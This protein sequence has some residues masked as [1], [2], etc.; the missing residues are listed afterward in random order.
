[1]TEYGTLVRIAGV[2][3]L[4]AYGRLVALLESQDAVAGVAL[5]HVRDDAFTFDLRLRAGQTN[6]VR[7]LDASGQLSV[8]P[9][10]LRPLPPVTVAGPGGAYCSRRAR[11]RLRSICT[12]VC[13]TD[14][15]RLVKPP[16]KS[17][18]RHLPNLISAARIVLS[19]ADH[20]VSAEPR[21]HAGDMAV[22]DRRRIRSASTASWPNALAGVRASEGS[23]MRWP[24]S[25]CCSRPSSAC[26]GSACSR[27]GW[28]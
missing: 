9:A 25:S 13:V 11:L 14:H 5:R 28:C 20:L 2:H 4:A 18:L 1:M 7:G 26:G 12:I 21:V 3:D 22:P 8:E 6:L 23:S 16:M 24:T 27:G 19:A 15:R 10:L 17:S